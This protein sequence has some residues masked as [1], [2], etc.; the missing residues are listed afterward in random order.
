M[1]FGGL[2]AEM[3]LDTE[4]LRELTQEFQREMPELLRRGMFDSNKRYEWVVMW[5]NL[6]EIFSSLE[7][8]APQLRDTVL[9]IRE[10]R[11]AGRWP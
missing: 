1:G 11:R 10:E 6:A 8:F 5:D 2:G 7:V 4:E 9:H 3:I